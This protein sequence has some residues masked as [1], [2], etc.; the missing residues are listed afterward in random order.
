VTS[1]L[2]DCILKRQGFLALPLFCA[3]QL[4]TLSLQIR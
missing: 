3:Q 2:P 4:H 1:Q